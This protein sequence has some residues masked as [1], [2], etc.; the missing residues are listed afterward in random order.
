MTSK[1]IFLT[2]ATGYIGGSILSLLLKPE[3]GIVPAH[4]ISVLIRGEEKAQTFKDL[5]VTP[6][7]FKSLDE[8]ELLRKVASEHDIVI[9]T[10][11]GYHTSSA[12]SLILGL[13]DRVAATGAKVHYFHTT[14]TSNLGD[15]PITGAYSESHIFSDTEDIYA[16]E[17][18]REALQ[19]YGQRTTDITAIETGLAVN[20]PTTLIMSPTIYGVGTG[21]FN[22]LSIQVPSMMRYALA[23]GKVEMIGSGEGAW[24]YVHVT[25][26]AELYLILLKRVLAGEE[27]PV[28]EKGVLFSSSGWFQWK[29]IARGI[30]DALFGIGALKTKEIESITVEEGAKWTNGDKLT[31]E[32][33]FASNSRTVSDIGFS[34]G[35][36]PVK[37]DADFKAH[38]LEE[39]KL[40][41]ENPTPRS[42]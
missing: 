34:L 38:F 9:H 2:G 28:G 17:K 39:A 26:L 29:D 23:A 35:W 8:S 6:I 32:L 42:W 11:S 3:S 10:A 19:P 36:K 40:V 30:A 5:G 27:V 22:K 37:T 31:A 12:K 33:G 7:L 13:G 15:Q 41:V 24:D 1:K 14:G 20:V 16:Y 4:S 21:Q 25:D 18:K